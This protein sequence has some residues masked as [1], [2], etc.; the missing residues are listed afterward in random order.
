MTVSITV[1]EIQ[2]EDDAGSSELVRHSDRVAFADG[3]VWP[4][5]VNELMDSHLPEENVDTLA[6]L[7]FDHLGHLPKKNETVTITDMKITILELIDNR[8]SRLKL[9]KTRKKESSRREKG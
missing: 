2:D 3:S 1:E 4:G 6:G 5:A 9:E 7:V 8:L